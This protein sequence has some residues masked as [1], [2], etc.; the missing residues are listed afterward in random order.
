MR[1]AQSSQI[2]IQAINLQRDRIGKVTPI[3]ESRDEYGRLAISCNH[4]QITW[5]TQYSC[6]RTRTKK[7]PDVI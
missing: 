6:R 3:P 2:S 7:H 5:L 1:L 4:T